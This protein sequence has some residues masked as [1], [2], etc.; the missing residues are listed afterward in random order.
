MAS[1]S[2][3]VGN[4]Q[5]WTSWLGGKTPQ[6][7]SVFKAFCRSVDDS[8]TLIRCEDYSLNPANGAANHSARRS[9]FQNLL[10]SF[11]TLL[12]RHTLIYYIHPSQVGS[13]VVLAHISGIRQQLLLAWRPVTLTDRL[14]RMLNLNQN[15]ST[16]AQILPTPQHQT[17][18]LVAKASRPVKLLRRKRYL[19]SRIRS[20]RTDVTSI[21]PR[22]SG[23][24]KL[25]RSSSRSF[26]PEKQKVRSEAI[27]T[28]SRFTVHRPCSTLTGLVFSYHRQRRRKVRELRR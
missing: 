13:G 12:P 7:S 20:R 27:S 19:A 10:C 21:L 24:Y 22:W 17:L 16:A 9:S 18:H 14:T 3:L 4:G 8:R 23:L 15:L 6:L 5:T 11:R 28:T 26:Q 1:Y 2:A 25:R